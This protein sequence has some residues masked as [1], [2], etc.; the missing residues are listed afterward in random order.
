MD[1]GLFDVGDTVMCI[2]ELGQL[3]NLELY[4][5]QQVFNDSDGDCYISVEEIPFSD[6]YA[7]RFILARRKDEN[8]NLSPFQQWEKVISA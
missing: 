1:V 7:S 4:T 3:R 6:F 5:V 8:S 2:N